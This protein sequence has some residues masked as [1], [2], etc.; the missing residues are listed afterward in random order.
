MPCVALRL[1]FSTANDALTILLKNALVT[2]LDYYFLH[3]DQCISVKEYKIYLLQHL[4]LCLAG[5][6]GAAPTPAAA[7]AA[8]E[9]TEE[10]PKPKEPTFIYVYYMFTI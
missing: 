3:V 8:P 1:N 7:A 5:D 4:L 6:D 2:S 10:A 9:K